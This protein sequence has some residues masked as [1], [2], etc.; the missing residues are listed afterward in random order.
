[1]LVC[2][3]LNIPI[4][5]TRNYGRVLIFRQKKLIENAP[6]KANSRSKTMLNPIEFRNWLFQRYG[7][8]GIL[9]L[10]LIAIFEDDYRGTLI[11]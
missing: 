3:N 5:S 10:I 7:K 6:D 9:F 2:A 1:M 8:N 4:I 11:I